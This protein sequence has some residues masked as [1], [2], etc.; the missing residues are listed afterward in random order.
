[1]IKDDRETRMD[2][3]KGFK[4][5]ILGHCEARAGGVKAN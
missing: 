2:G 3:L 1:M 4:R 5:T